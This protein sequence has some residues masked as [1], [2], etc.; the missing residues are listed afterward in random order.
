MCIF[1]KFKLFKY[2]NCVK[3]LSILKYALCIVRIFKVVHVYIHIVKI[4]SDLY[5]KYENV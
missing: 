5:L 4:I 3:P 2:N 1:V